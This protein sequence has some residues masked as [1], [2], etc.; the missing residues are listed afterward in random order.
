LKLFGYP[1][2]NQKYGIGFDIFPVY[3]N[4]LKYRKSFVARKSPA[5]GEAGQLIKNPPRVRNPWRVDY[6]KTPK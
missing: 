3:F 4:Q 5:S 2:R 1:P 6:P